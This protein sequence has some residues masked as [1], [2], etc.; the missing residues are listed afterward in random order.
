MEARNPYKKAY[1]RKYTDLVEQER[2][3][4]VAWLRM[5]AD[6]IIGNLLTGDYDTEAC[7]MA[8]RAIEIAANDIE[9]GEHWK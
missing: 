7:E 6:Q 8:A 4:I 5:S 3:V 9:Q 2:D 1:V